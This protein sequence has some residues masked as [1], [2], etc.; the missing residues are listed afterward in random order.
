ML[1][2]QAYSSYFYLY[3]MFTLQKYLKI[4]KDS[5]KRN[6][7][8]RKN[9][10]TSRQQKTWR[11]QPLGEHQ[12]IIRS[13]V[14]WYCRECNSGYCEAFTFTERPSS[15][16]TRLLLNW[17]RRPPF[18]LSPSCSSLLLYSYSHNILPENLNKIVGQSKKVTS[19]YLCVCAYRQV[20]RCMSLYILSQSS[21]N[22]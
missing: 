8:T 21:S 15:Q 5:A 4:E 7:H 19:G 18:L 3:N 10:S 9:I 16:K 2:F 17:I 13:L 1:I 22:L 20:L 14:W 6:R 12:S 11:E